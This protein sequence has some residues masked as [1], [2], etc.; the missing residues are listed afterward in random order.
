MTSNND[1][2]GEAELSEAEAVRLQRYIDNSIGETHA[3][4]NNIELAKAAGVSETTIRNIRKGSAISN[5]TFNKL[6]RAFGFQPSQF[7]AQLESLDRDK[8]LKR[9]LADEIRTAVADLPEEDQQEFLDMIR[10]RRERKMR[11]Q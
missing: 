10:R 9:A 5:N 11:N 3:F 6:S 4:A 1:A 7:K 2:L 8:E